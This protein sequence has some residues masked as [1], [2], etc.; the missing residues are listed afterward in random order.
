MFV[1]EAVRLLNRLGHLLLRRDL[2]VK[3]NVLNLQDR[4]SSFFNIFLYRNGFIIRISGTKTDCL[5]DVSV[6]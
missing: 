2:N 5:Y 6:A 3:C 1:A 4:L